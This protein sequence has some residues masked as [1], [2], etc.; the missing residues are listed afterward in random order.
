MSLHNMIHFP[1]IELTGAPTPL[2]HLPRLSDYPE[3]DIFIKRNDV[4]PRLSAVIRCASSNL[5]RQMPGALVPMCC[6]PLA[7]FSLTMCATPQRWRQS[8]GS[9]PLGALAYVE[10][11]R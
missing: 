10:C 9:C 5:W 11:A 8:L 1:R 4:T 7:L 3:R 2:E 6:L